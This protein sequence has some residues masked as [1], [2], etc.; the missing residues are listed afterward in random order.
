MIQEYLQTFKGY[1]DSKGYIHDIKERKQRGKFFSGILTKERVQK[2][3]E[4]ELEEILSRLW[5]MS[6]W[7]NKG[8]LLQKKSFRV[9]G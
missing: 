8:Y 4:F 3:S 2:L 5:A 9:M 1:V 6:L 7:G